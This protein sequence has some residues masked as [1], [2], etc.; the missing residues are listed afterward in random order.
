MAESFAP[1]SRSANTLACQRRNYDRQATVV[2]KRMVTP[3]EKLI[4]LKRSEWRR[5]RDDAR[6]VHRRIGRISNALSIEVT[7]RAQ[8][9]FDNSHPYDNGQI[10]EYRHL[11]PHGRIWIDYA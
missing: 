1:S 6:A 2:K 10:G 11:L 4:Q 3:K 7:R 5:K 8:R 9:D